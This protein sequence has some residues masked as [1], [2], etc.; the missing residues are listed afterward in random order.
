MKDYRVIYHIGDSIGLETTMKK[1]ML[2]KGD[3][4]E[5][6]LT[7]KGTMPF[8]KLE[9]VTL[10]KLNRLGTILKIINNETTI[11][12]AAY[13]IFINIGT[14]LCNYKLLRD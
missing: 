11:F 4:F 8:D 9:K 2:V 12:L 14:R 10:E 5:S 3:N 1:G 6:L 13:R 7:D